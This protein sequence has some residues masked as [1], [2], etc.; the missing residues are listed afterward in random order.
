MDASRGVGGARADARSGSW[1]LRHAAETSG[2]TAGSCKILAIATAVRDILRSFVSANDNDYRLR[3]AP[4]KYR[5]RIFRDLAQDFSDIV[6][7]SATIELA[8]LPDTVSGVS[9]ALAVIIDV[10]KKMQGICRR[11][12]KDIKRLGSLYWAKLDTWDAMRSAT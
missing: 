7:A 9:D 10:A 4:E 6:A 11:A 2:F 5:T 1:R 8:K 3:C 12:K